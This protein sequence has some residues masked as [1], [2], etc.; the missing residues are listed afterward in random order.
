MCKQTDVKADCKLLGGQLESEM[1]TDEFSPLTIV[2]LIT[3]ETQ[4]IC[5]KLS[6]QHLAYRS[7]NVHDV[8]GSEY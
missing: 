6:P 3:R 1:M 2:A 7:Y 4:T 5:I 8:N